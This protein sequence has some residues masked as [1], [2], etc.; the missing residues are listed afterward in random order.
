MSTPTL[1]P[2][3][4]AALLRDLAA[5]AAPA[6]K[7]PQ[8][9]ASRVLARRRRTRVRR[10]LV[11]AG[12]LTLVAGSLAAGTW[13]GHSRYFGYYEPS[14]T[15]APTINAGDTAVLDKTLTPQRDDL[16]LVTVTADGAPFDALKRVI[17]LPGDTVACPATPEGSCDGVEVNGIRIDDAYLA[18]L[19]TKPFPA[20]K[21]PADRLFLLG[22]NRAESSDSRNWQPLPPTPIKGVVVE[23]R[24][25]GQAPEAVPG[26]P[27]HERPGN[28]LIDP[29][30]PVPPASVQSVAP[31]P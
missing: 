20:T 29:L 22:D 18:A 15:M 2:D 17:G 10:R 13:V 1:T 26:A 6:T 19:T 14:A 25:P 3:D 5:T 9:M 11:V 16:V 4:A 23:I 31:T 12:A 27:A 28:N 30:G 21:V 24:R 7:C 8:D